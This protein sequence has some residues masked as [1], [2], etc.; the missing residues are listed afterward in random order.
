MVCDKN[1]VN[2]QKKFG[3]DYPKIR[4]LQFQE[5]V[6][7]NAGF[8]NLSSAISPLQKVNSWDKACYYFSKINT[9]YDN[10]W[11][12][13][14]DVYFYSENT[15]LDIDAQFTMSDLLTNRCTPKSD[16]M[17]SA[18]H[19]HWCL[20]SINLCEPHFRAM[21]CAAR[22]SRKLFA[23][24]DKYASENN[25]LFYLETLF[26]TLALHYGLKYDTP[27]ELS[28]I[29]YRHDWGIENFNNSHL[30]HPVKNMAMH[31]DNRRIERFV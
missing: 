26:P 28:C 8:T 6:C 7:S 18:W 9:D 4:F 20:F 21:V 16:D 3:A 11:L 24:V 19:W 29:E 30:F 5:S 23:F 22:V 15:L 31:D 14:D 2:Y 1:L 25:T 12:I 27:D 17:N 10:V 13:E